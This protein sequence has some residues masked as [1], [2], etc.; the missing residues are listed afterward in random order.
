MGAWLVMFIDNE[1]NYCALEILF[2]YPRVQIIEVHTT[3]DLP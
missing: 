3:E 1:Y 2:G